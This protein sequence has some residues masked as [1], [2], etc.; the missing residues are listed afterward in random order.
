M[1]IKLNGSSSGYT[2]IEAA[3]AAGDNTLTLPTTSGTLMTTGGTNTFTANQV[4]EV[5]DNSNAALRITQLGTGLAIRV[6]DSAN[7]DSSPF[8]VTAR[9]DVGVGTASPSTPTGYTTLCVNGDTTGSLVDLMKSGVMAGRLV[10]NGGF[11]VV[12]TAASVPLVFSPGGT[13]TARCETG[14]FNIGAA[15]QT[16][17]GGKLF[18][19]TAVTNSD[20]AL[21]LRNSASGSNRTTAAFVNGNTQVGSIVTSASA[22]TYN[23]SS[24]YRLKEDVKP[25]PDAAERVMALRPVNF[26]WKLSGER[27]D[28]FIAHEAQAI[29]PNAVTGVKDAMRMVDV[30]DEKTGS[31]VTVEQ[32]DY[33]S[34]DHSKLVPLL[35][36]A[37]QEAL[38]KIDA[39]ET[40]IA[41]LEN[42]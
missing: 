39:L 13:E 25:V 27:T 35:T 12:E 32:P 31:I 18:V 34:I 33:Q 4:I 42:A 3:A 20:A 19:E 29:V 7:P 41:T 26:A 23:T 8:V 38:T 40:R 28:G 2:Q 37:L 30:K 6:E 9:G 17:W 21:V 36:A 14:L 11:L 16:I 5:T 24:D 15:V 22:T 1:P 10:T